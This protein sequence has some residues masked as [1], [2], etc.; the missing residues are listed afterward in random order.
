L[1]HV[2]LEAQRERRPQLYVSALVVDGGKVQTYPSLS[3]GNQPRND[4]NHTPAWEELQ[5]PISWHGLPSFM[6]GTHRPRMYRR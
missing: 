3:L 5:I 1:G 4:H 2:L 6:L